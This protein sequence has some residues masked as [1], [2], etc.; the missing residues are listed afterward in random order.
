MSDPNPLTS[1]PTPTP[2]PTLGAA[3]DIWALAAC[4]FAAVC[5]TGPFSDRGETVLP[6]V[7][8]YLGTAPAGTDEGW[9]CH[10]LV[11]TSFG[12]A[13]ERVGARVKAR[14]EAVRAV[15]EGRGDGAY[16]GGG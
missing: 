16:W 9:A 7:T 14:A 2:P 13:L 15:K 10:A 4:M 8:A 3:A 11:D 12:H 5:G 6:A 1:N